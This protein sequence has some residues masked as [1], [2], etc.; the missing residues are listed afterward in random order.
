MQEYLFPVVSTVLGPAEVAYWGML[1]QAFAHI[2]FNMP[3]LIPRT[4]WTVIEADVQKRL[5]QFDLAVSDAIT[6]N[7]LPKSRQTWLAQQEPIVIA[8]AFSDASK[9]IRAEHQRLL[10][11]FQSLPGIDQVGDKNFAQIARQLDYLQSK[12]ESALHT[13]HEVALRKWDELEHALRPLGKP[14]ERVY[15]VAVYLAKYGRDWID[16]WVTAADA[17]FDHHHVLML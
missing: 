17:D 11:H 8:E 2:D 9:K 7:F 14:Q 15:N 16:E 10:S 6:A 4:E 3:I 12:M 13:K 1:K 5:A